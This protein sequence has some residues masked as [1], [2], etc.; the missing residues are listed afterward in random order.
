MASRTTAT[1]AMI[2]AKSAERYWLTPSIIRRWI[3]WRCDRPALRYLRRDGP[4]L[5]QPRGRRDHRDLCLRKFVGTRHAKEMPAVRR[6]R[7]SPRASSDRPKSEGHT[8]GERRLHHQLPLSEVRHPQGLTRW[9]ERESNPHSTKAAD[10]QSA[11]LTTC[12]ICPSE[13]H[14]KGTHGRPHAPRLDHRHRSHHVALD[15]RAALRA[16]LARS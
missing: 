7:P 9:A 8:D 11:E 6:H 2:A 1:A 12:S 14:S 16:R 15:G 5:G 10:L 4:T 13:H 3:G